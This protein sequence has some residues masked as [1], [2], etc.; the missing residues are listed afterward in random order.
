VVIPALDSAATIV[1]AVASAL[2][3]DYEGEI[4]IVVAC[5]PDDPTRAALEPFA[6]D[7]VTIA[8]NP[9]GGTAAGLNTAIAASAGDVV[10][11][12]DAH[13]AFPRDYVR[14]AVEILAETGADNVGGVQEALGDTPM[15]RAIAMAQTTPLG[16]GDA[17]YRTGGA[18]GPVDTVYLGV[19]RREALDRVGGFDVTQKRNQDYELNWRLRAS[20]GTVFFHPDLRVGYRPRSSLRA[21]W[22]QYFEY[23]TW[24]RVMLRRHPGSLRWRQAAP[25]ALVLALILSAGLLLTPW[26]AAGAIVPIV[27]VGALLLAGVGLFARRRDPAALLAPAALA[28]MHV[29]WGTGFLYGRAR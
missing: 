1:A 20:G 9:G 3:Q 19:F 22:R 24:K 25:P 28:T 10:A 17:R 8:S 6:G 16:V 26:R 14:R 4:D 18:P 2:D 11:R 15:Q 21:L 5:P 12:L 29:A 27:Y 23:G 13:A 7:R